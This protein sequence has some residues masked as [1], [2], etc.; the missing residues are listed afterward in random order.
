MKV[1]VCSRMKGGHRRAGKF[2]PD[3]NTEIDVD[4]KQLAAIKADGNI[5][6]VEAP[7]EEPEPPAKQPAKQPAKD[8]A[9]QDTTK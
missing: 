4:E 1:I 3:G 2:I 5:V 8:P 7:A 9:K 6:C